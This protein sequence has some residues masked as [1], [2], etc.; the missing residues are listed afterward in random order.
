MTTTTKNIHVDDCKDCPCKYVTY[1]DS[2]FS[3]A[4]SNKYQ[5]LKNRLDSNPSSVN[6]LDDYGYSALHYAAREN[7]ISVVRLLLSKGS[8]P[9]LNSC[10]NQYLLLMRHHLLI[11]LLRCDTVTTCSVYR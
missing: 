9:D 1:S 3:L 10:G 11:G 7:H 6:K 4:A 2:L 8:K 5:E